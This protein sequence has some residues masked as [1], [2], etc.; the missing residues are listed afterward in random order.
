LLAGCAVSSEGPVAVAPAYVYSPPAYAYVAP[1]VA[2]VTT[3][4][5]YGY[6]TY[7]PTYYSRGYYANASPTDPGTRGGN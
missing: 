3:Y 5:A 6:Q 4:P 2:Q 1:P 7:T